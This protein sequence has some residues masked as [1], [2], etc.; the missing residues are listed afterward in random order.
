MAELDPAKRAQLEKMGVG[1]LAVVFLMVF[2]TG[3]AKTLGLFG[4]SAPAVAPAPAAVPAEPAAFDPMPAASAPAAMTR[5][6][7]ASGT[8]AVPGLTGEPRFA[9]QGVR[10]PFES[11]LP[12]PEPEVVAVDPSAAGGP[13]VVAEEPPVE[14]PILTVQGIVWGDGAPPKAII[15]RQVYDIGDTLTDGAAI[16]AIDAAGVIVEY[17]G[18]FWRIV[19]GSSIAEE[20]DSSAVERVAERR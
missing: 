14:P 7:A 19:S 8:P 18:L 5:A 2:L 13:A 16:H 11:Q 10:S 4:G 12:Q 1:V 17:H 3:P 20:L 6:P 15:D 9:A